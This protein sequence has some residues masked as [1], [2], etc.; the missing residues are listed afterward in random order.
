MKTFG[1]FIFALLISGQAYADWHQGT[2]THITYGYDGQ[3]VT[4]G[5]SG[6]SKSNCTCY[7]A[8]PDYLC[9]DFNRGTNKQELATLLSAETTGATIAIYIDETTC[10]LLALA[11]YPH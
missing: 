2:V 6:L 11:F 7:P 8:W 5:L 4:F 3:T 9:L 10:K 1:L